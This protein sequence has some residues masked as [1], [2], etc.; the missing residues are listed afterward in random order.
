MSASSLSEFD[1]PARLGTPP[2]AA[3]ATRPARIVLTTTGTLGDVL[4]LVA[5]AVRLRELGAQPVIATMADYA[6]AARAEGIAFRAVRPGAADLAADGL[7]EVAVARAVTRDLR[8]G[9]DIMLPH[10][11]RTIQ[12]LRAVIAS[13]D[14]VIAGPLSVVARLVAEQAG[15]PVATVMLQPMAFR[16]VADPPRMREAPLA[17]GVARRCGPGAVRLLYSI[18]T[19]RGRRSLRPIARLRRDL[20]LPPVRDEIVAGIAR[21]EA[22]FAMYPPAFA[23]V[24]TDAPAQAHSAG[25]PGYDGPRRRARAL[26]PALARFLDSGPPPLVFT[27]GSFVI[28]APG[29]F[30]E[31]SAA[32]AQRLGRRA[33]LLVGDHALAAFT[34]L[35]DQSVVV[36]GHVQHS[37]L[38]GRVSAVVHHGGMG[39]TAQALY[40]GVPQLVC[41]LFGDQFDNAERLRRLGVAAVLPLRRY[42]SAA[43]VRALDR[44]LTGDAALRARDLAPDMAGE[45]GAGFVARWV[46][47]WCAAARSAPGS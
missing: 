16:S 27:L 19:L 20:R 5:I 4:P 22:I 13:A 30:Y 6:G 9:F 35:A 25:F 10:L 17:C 24:P 14:L 41:P 37:A 28:H 39:T 8:A 15:V 32:A 26:D 38:F 18:A 45:D 7:D 40:V 29:R 46:A 23:P 12:D 47:D 2:P 21:S 34:S 1:G 33:V 44:L 31:A 43:A 11:D 3:P 42:S 36:A